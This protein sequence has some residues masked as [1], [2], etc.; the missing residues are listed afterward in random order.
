MAYFHLE[1]L[2]SSVLAKKGASLRAPVSAK[3]FVN[4]AEK[5]PCAFDAGF[6][7]NPGDCS[8]N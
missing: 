3:L 7:D 6:A 4:V 8:V 5:R 1:Y 2:C